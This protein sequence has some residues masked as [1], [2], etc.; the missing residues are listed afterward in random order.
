MFQAEKH[1]LERMHS[2]SFMNKL[3]FAMFPECMAAA[4][5]Y[6]SGSSRPIESDDCE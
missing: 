2:V 4:V 1:F 3:G 5:S 6:K